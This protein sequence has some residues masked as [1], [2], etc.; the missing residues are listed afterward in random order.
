MTAPRARI[1]QIAQAIASTKEA[2]RRSLVS[3]WS[4][5]MLTHEILLKSVS[6][7]D[8]FEFCKGVPALYQKALTKK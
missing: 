7:Q 5:P 1:I 3:C 8:L 2:A 4:W 6:L